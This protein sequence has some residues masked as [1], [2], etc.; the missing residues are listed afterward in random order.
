M[1][2]IIISGINGKMGQCVYAAAADEGLSVICGVDNKTSANTTCPV[3]LSFKNVQ[4]KADVVIDFSSPT[5]LDELL[6]F[7]LKTKTAL[8]I[9]TTGL[10]GNDEIEIVEAAKK[11]PIFKTSNTSLAMNVLICAAEQ[12]AEKLIDYD[13]EIIERHHRLKKDSPSGTAETIL[14]ELKKTRKDYSIVYGRHGF[15]L[16]N[17]KE[18]G[19]HSVRGGGVAGEHEVCFYG[20]YDTLKIVHTAQDKRLFAKG[21]VE[22]A[23]FIVNKNSGL[24]GMKDL[25]K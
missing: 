17:A 10:S 12:I 20:D 25:K 16:R 9:A 14:N 19:V 8:V 11:I 23:K 4:E 13:I 3:Y 1:K 15:S 5:I 2:N 7:C 21:A 18:I 24:Y 6:S 22:A